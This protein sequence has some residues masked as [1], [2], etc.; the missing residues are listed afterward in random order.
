M[1]KFGIIINKVKDKDFKFTTELIRLL[2]K[3]NCEFYLTDEI[4][5]S[6]HLE[7]LA[8]TEKELYKLCDIIIAI[9][10]DGTM[11]S[12]SRNVMKYGV[13]ILGINMGHLGFI[14]E[15]ETK[16]VFTALQK[17]IANDYNIENRMMI[18]ADIYEES[19]IVK[20]L[21]S[22]NDICI[23]KGALAK[24]ITLGVYI[25]NNYFDIYNADG[26]LVSTP[27]GSTAYSLSAGG[28][29]VAPNANIML[30]TPICPHTLASR[31]MVV[32]NDDIVRVHISEECEKAYLT[33]D[34]Q[35]SLQ[36]FGGDNVIIKKAPYC[37]KFVKVS[38]MSFYDV[39]RKKM[40]L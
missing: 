2:Q 1:T 31:T 25:N 10:G 14:T 28:P 34:G 35:K 36:L 22:L 38:N 11:L 30:I 3:L 20:T 5:K 21:Y 26:L 37:A 18:E 29:I 6:I 23:S 40:K 16:D 8:L 27:T 12:V 24:I 13:P 17:V 4:A 9:G 15:V 7:K 39:L 33:A 19:K 32:S